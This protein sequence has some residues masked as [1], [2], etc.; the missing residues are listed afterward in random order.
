[1]DYPLSVFELVARVSSV[2]EN[3]IQR[4][5]AMSSRKE[6]YPLWYGDARSSWMVPLGWFAA[7]CGSRNEF[8]IVNTS[9]YIVLLLIKQKIFLTSYINKERSRNCSRKVNSD[10]FRKVHM[11]NPS[12]RAPKLSLGGCARVSHLLGNESARLVSP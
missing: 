8:L 12:Q 2:S 1:M 9:L 3:Q 4:V 10:L 6:A 5:P 11:R 7:R